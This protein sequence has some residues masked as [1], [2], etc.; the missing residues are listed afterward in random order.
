MEKTEELHDWLK[1]MG[2]VKFFLDP[3]WRKTADYSCKGMGFSTFY[4]DNAVGVTAAKKICFGCPVQRLCLEYALQYSEDHGI[5]GGVSERSR[6]KM[7]L[8][9]IRHLKKQAKL[10]ARLKTISQ[11]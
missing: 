11:S 6:K 2:D 9:R 1:P 7:R 8:A 5:W 4:P 3:E 10:D